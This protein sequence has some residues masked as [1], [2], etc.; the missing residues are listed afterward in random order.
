MIE[1]IVARI[2]AGLMEINELP[3]ALRKK[4]LAVL[5]EKDNEQDK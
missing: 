1:I 2:K 4:V 3:E 5:I